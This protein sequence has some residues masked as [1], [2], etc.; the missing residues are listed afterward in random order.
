MAEL[1]DTT[2]AEG[3]TDITKG[4]EVEKTLLDNCDKQKLLT[5]VRCTIDNN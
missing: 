2:S 3:T 5:K 1:I 4:A